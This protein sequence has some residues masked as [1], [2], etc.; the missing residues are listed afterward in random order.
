MLSMTGF[1]RGVVSREGREITMEMKSV[2]HRF[3]DISLR[4]PRAL[5]F[6]EDAVKER[7]GGYMARGHLE[8]S[9]QYKNT[10]EDSRTVSVDTAL[11]RQYLSALET[12]KAL[13]ASG[14]PELKLLARI[15]DVLVISCAEEDQEAV[16]KIA[17]EAVDQACVQIIS[18]RE[19]EGAKIHR[20]MLAKLEHI[21]ALTAQVKVRSEDAAKDYLEKLRRRIRELVEGAAVDEQRLAQE[22]AIM[23]D[24]LSI[25][26]EMVRLDAHISG[27]RA[28][29]EQDGP[30]GRKLD[31]MLQE[32]NR[33]VNTIGS[34][35]MDVE[36][37]SRVVD[38]KA[39][40]EKLREQVQNIE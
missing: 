4:G 28:Y 14:E 26:E 19:R 27:M 9:V 30:L 32:I 40:L 33:E 35:A 16:L 25:D 21:E 12:L 3:L 20:D 39:E 6:I 31:F 2:N 24:R 23:A 18:M 7:I 10:R 34:K 13:G 11:A 17:L 38:I 1:G 29:M 36:I 15:N 37:Q 8:V 22:A 5:G